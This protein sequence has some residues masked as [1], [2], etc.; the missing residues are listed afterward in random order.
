MCGEIERNGEAA[1]VT[2]LKVGLLSRKLPAG[3]EKIHGNFGKNNRLPD[4]DDVY[5]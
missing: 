3:A 1:V 4:F 5:G 2:Y